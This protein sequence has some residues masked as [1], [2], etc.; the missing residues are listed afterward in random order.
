M[1]IRI[2]VVRNKMFKR[3]SWRYVV[4]ELVHLWKSCL[5]TP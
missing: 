1:A 2:K 3:A 4:P 5:M